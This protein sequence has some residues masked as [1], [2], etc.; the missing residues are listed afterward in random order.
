MF[1]SVTKR[2]RNVN[3]F[4]A[5]SILY[6][7]WGTSKAYVIGLAFAVA[8]Y[9]SFWLIALVSLLSLLV[10]I[11]Y[12]AICRLYPS[13]GGVYAAVRQKS[14]SL[15]LVGA[16][17]LIA[18]YLV[19]AALSALSALNYLGLPDPATWAVAAIGGVGLLNYLGPRHTGNLAFLI[20]I[21]TL[22]VVIL[23]AV[24]SFPHLGTA[25]HNLQPLSGGFWKNWS[26]FV[27]VIVALSGIEA[28]ANATGVMKLNPGTTLKNPEITQTSTPAIL[29]VMMEVAFF[30]TL[31]SLATLALPGLMPMDGEIQ[32]PGHANVRD[33]LLRYMGEVFAGDLLGLRA[34]LTFGIIVSIAFGALLL[35]AVN[36][37]I[38]A[39]TSLLFVMSREGELPKQL[40]KLNGF[41][42][43]IFPLL[44]ATFIPMVLIYSVQDVPGLA[45]LY[46]V[47]FIGAIATNLGATSL[48]PKSALN[49]LERS[50][51]VG[52]F[53]VMAAIEV[54]LFIE[55]AHARA[56]VVAVLAIGLF[57]RALAVEHQQA[58]W[59]E[60]TAEL[61]PG[62]ETLAL[63]G[64]IQAPDEGSTL[65]AVT[66]PGKTLEY[67]IHDQ[68]RRTKPLIVLFLREQLVIT[69]EDKNRHWLE[70]PDACAVY[71]HAKARV[72]EGSLRFLYMVSDSI[73]GS[74]IETAVRLRASRV[75]VGMPRQSRLILLIQ[76][77][78]MREV[79]YR[80]PRN[81]DLIIV[82]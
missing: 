64:P 31:F 29:A 32:A 68:K 1:T 20:A 25:I 40:Q 46:A 13:G 57:L 6:G 23:L 76:G 43:P 45:D 71:E 51:M 78:I 15:A 82:S 70:D 14:E 69:E 55:K 36:T 54:T 21:P 62:P 50:L 79:S 38:V 58:I 3:A 33:A 9:S 26:G 48:D 10:G 56:F 65:C 81:I 11:N 27:G 39:L 42:V 63:S 4:Q 34:G 61:T 8:G 19:T 44:I 53:A 28:I 12:M 74:I 75:V 35:S 22:I 7:D 59:K 80:L 17:F 60:K 41:G 77:D 16:F 30:T 52:T 5:A 73:A 67:A 47:G 72:S 66:H 37:A 24:F 49:K 2:P 18:D